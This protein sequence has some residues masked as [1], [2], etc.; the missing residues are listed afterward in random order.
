MLHKVIEEIKN[1]KN[2]DRYN[3]FCVNDAL[4]NLKKVQE[5]LEARENYPQQHFEDGVKH[6]K[7]VMK[8]V[9]LLSVITGYME[10]TGSR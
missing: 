3:D 10:S 1:L 2:G 8:T 9:P 6:A 5:C 7:W 4:S